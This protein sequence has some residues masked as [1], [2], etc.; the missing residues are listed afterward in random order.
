MLPA[1]LEHHDLDLG[2]HLMRAR[3]GPVRP[4]DQPLQAAGLIPA[5]PLMHRLPGTP[6]CW[7]T[8]VTS[9]PSAMT[10]NTAR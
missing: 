3:R 5:Q 9:W 4:I 6:Q 2:R 10:A 7:A 1:Q 8:A